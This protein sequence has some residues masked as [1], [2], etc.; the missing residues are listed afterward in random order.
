MADQI[1]QVTMPESILG[2]P[3]TFDQ[4]G[5]LK[6]AKFFIFTVKGGEFELAE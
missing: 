3:I 1:R 2:Q 6:N 4:N 5:D